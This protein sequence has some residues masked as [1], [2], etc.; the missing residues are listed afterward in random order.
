M[1]RML[2]SLYGNE[3]AT[4]LLCKR[5]RTN[6]YWT[7]DETIKWRK[8]MKLKEKYSVHNDQ[9]KYRHYLKNIKN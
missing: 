2:K 7:M 5:K 8:E 3:T 6:K 9:N 4:K 1:E